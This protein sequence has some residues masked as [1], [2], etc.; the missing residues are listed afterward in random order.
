MDKVDENDVTEKKRLTR[1]L[2]QGV[3]QKNTFKTWQSIKNEF[4]LLD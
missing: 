1:F 2:K 3:I 4:L